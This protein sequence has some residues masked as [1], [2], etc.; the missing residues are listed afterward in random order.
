MDA[1][2]W[3]IIDF[4]SVSGLV[5]NLER[6]SVGVAVL[7]SAEDLEDGAPATLSSPASV[8]VGPGLLGTPKNACS[9]RPDLTSLHMGLQAG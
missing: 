2:L 9:W 7:G 3:S 5:V 1:R 8:P 4:G 6:N